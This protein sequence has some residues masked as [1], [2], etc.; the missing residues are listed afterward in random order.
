IRD[1]S[2]SGPVAAFTPGTVPDNLP[3]D[4][5]LC[6]FRVAQEALQN[7]IK[8]SHAQTIDVSLGTEAEALR[9]RVT[10]DGIGFD[11]DAAQKNGLGLISMR[12]RVEAIGAAIQVTSQP[13]AG[14][15]IEISAVLDRDTASEASRDPERP[16][17]AH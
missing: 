3:S 13:G 2:H 12:E 15:T 14:T 8:Y 7:A 11:V 6:F 9:L 17:N 1:L 5:T 4:V 16:I 10:D